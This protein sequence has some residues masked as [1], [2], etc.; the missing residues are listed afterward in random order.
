MNESDELLLSVLEDNGT[1]LLSS[2]REGISSV[3]RI[4][5][6]LE[7][8]GVVF[9]PA[10]MGIAGQY[11]YASGQTQEMERCLTDA[12]AAFGAENRFAIY[13]QIYRALLHYD[14]DVEHY[15]KLLN[16]ASFYLHE[17]GEPM[18]FLLPEDADRLA[19]IRREEEGKAKQLCVRTLGSFSVTANADGRELPW[20]TRK[21]KELFAYL[22]ELEGQAIDRSRL[23]EV[24]WEDI[25]DNAVA[26][27]HN[28][29]YNM[30]KELSAYGMEGIVVYEKKRYRLL[31]DDI[32]SD[33]VLL[34]RVMDAV[35]NTDMDELH[36][37]K[38]FFLNYRGTYLKDID[39][40]WAYTARTAAD[41]SYR[42]GCMLLAEDAQ[43]KGDYKTAV[44]LYDNILAVSP[45][46]E[47]AVAKLL[48]LYTKQ[49]RWKKREECYKNF[50]ARLKEDLGV[51]PGEEVMLAYKKVKTG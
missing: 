19:L 46:E 35:R 50:T 45:Y 23:I 14:T 41:E 15:V 40:P 20:R 16:N 10:A 27:L 25:P 24:L 11:Y 34:H 12:D 22:L 37:E 21:G 42:M 3:G 18:P 36:R 4:I 33:S 48:E 2:G 6:Y 51:A 44:K 7:R 26:L 38:D 17:H 28:M 31:M 39:S 13:R 9:S 32:S 5:A 47:S 43:E 1:A 8:E 49:R 30:R 29:I